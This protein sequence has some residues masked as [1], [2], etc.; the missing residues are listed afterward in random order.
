M[1]ANTSFRTFPDSLG[2]DEIKRRWADAVDMSLHEDGHSYSGEI[3]MLGPK[4]AQWYEPAFE[5]ADAF[6]QAD[7]FICEKHEKWRPAMAV[8][9]IRN[10]IKMWLIGGWCS[11]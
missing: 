5:G 9:Y 10:G 8:A 7:E 2:K 4:I 3:G 1:G 11:S 6:N